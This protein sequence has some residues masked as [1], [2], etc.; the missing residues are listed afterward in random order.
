MRTIGFGTAGWDETYPGVWRQTA[1]AQR[2]T[3]TLYRFDPGAAFP[4]HRH[5]QEQL[6]FVLRGSVEFQN[7]RARMT[8][9]ANELIFIPPN[10]LHSA[11]AGPEGAEVVSVV[12]PARRG[13]DDYTVEGRG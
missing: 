12:S 2:M 3:L 4:M 9:R 13:T 7:T 11:T 5:D 1:S 6:A 10:E 8:C